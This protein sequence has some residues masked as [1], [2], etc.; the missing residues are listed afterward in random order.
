MNDELLRSHRDAMRDFR[1]ELDVFQF[2]Q[3]VDDFAIQIN[4]MRDVLGMHAENMQRERRGEAMAY[5]EEA[6]RPRPHWNTGNF[7]GRKRQVSHVPP[8]NGLNSWRS[9]AG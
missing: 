9:A 6:L 2:R 5:G 7:S 3:A 8:T 4:R 1:P